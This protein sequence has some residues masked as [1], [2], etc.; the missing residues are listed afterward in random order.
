MSLG[1]CV[2]ED[3]D[4]YTEELCEAMQV[5]HSLVYSKLKGAQVCSRL[6]FF[7]QFYPKEDYLTGK[8]LF[9]EYDPKVHST[10]HISTR[11]TFVY[12]I[13]LKGGDILNFSI[14]ILCIFAPSI[15]VNI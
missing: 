8:Y 3:P 12:T 5:T 9:F 11:G 15:L 7:I 2:Q 6:I 1:P 10:D 13:P 4:T 14:H